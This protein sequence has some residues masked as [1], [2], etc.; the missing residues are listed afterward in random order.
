M[1]RS[2]TLSKLFARNMCKNNQMLQ[3]SEMDNVN[4]E[5][6]EHTSMRLYLQL[7]S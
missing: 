2:Y 1:Q 4:K 6:A 7:E 5:G 3:G